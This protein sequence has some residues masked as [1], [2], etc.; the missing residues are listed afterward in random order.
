MK[1]I[2]YA[3]KQMKKWNKENELTSYWE[4]SVQ[5]NV[6][7]ITIHHGQL[8]SNSFL[9]FVRENFNWQEYFSSMTAEKIFEDETKIKVIIKWYE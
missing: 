6:V 8:L 4:M 2:K 9:F 5:N 7:K 1:A 3:L